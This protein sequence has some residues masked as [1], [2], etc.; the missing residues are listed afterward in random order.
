MEKET[1][2]CEIINEISQEESNKISI[3][4][5]WL[6]IMVIFIH[7]YSEEIHFSSG[8]VNLD[9]PIWLNVFEYTISQ[10]ISR[11]AVPTFFFLASF[12]LYRKKYLWGNN[13]RR[14]CFSL[15]IPYVLLNTFWIV[16]YGICQKITFSK[17]F[18]SQSNTIIANWKLLDWVKAYLGSPQNSYPLLYTLWFVRD[19][20]VLNLLANV[21]LWFIKKTKRFSII[22]FITL[23][24][25]CKNTQIFFLDI[26]AVCFWGIGCWFVFNRKLSMFDKYKFIPVCLVYFVLIIVTVCL[27]N[28]KNLIFLIINRLCSI[29]G[30]IFF[31]RFTTTIRS[32]FFR[33]KLLLISKYSF[34]I[35]IF[36]EMNLSMLKKICIKLFPVLPIFQLLEY[37]F[38]PVVI[39]CGCLLFSVILNRKFPKIYNIIIGGRR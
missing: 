36:H 26:Q 29:I 34:A 17:A 9:T 38:I 7:S 6:T 8:N 22:F 13:I 27:K 33:E 12:F 5:V 28:N 2:N 20:F 32:S 15:L 35:Y 1:R 25:L 31:Y 21:F 14:K 10:V 37:V 23:W 11:C 16:F 24:L 39:F 3:L 18:F 30:M 4:K 19:L